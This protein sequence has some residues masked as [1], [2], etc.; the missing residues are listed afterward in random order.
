MSP[1]KHDKVHPRGLRILRRVNKMAPDAAQ[2]I[3][4]QFGNLAEVQRASLEQLT[5]VEGIGDDLAANVQETLSRL[6]ES[7]I[8]EQYS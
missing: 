6:T 2:A 5:S 3:T 1:Y 4:A 8:L 7:A